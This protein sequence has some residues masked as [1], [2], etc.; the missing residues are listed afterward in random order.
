ML[1]AVEAEV[2]IALKRLRGRCVMVGDPRQ[3]PATVFQRPG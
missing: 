3:L 2:V 1:Q